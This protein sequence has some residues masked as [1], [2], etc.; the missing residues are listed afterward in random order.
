MI[1]GGFS[2]PEAQST[3]FNMIENEGGELQLRKVEKGKVGSMTAPDIFL[4]NGACR[5]EEETNDVYFVGKEHIHIFN[6]ET[7]KFRTLRRVNG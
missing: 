6:E 5:I 2:K 3:V 4:F 7:C 1:F